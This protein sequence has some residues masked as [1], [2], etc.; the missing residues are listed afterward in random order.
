MVVEI[1]CVLR[2]EDGRAFEVDLT[3]DQQKIDFSR[4]LFIFSDNLWLD[5]ARRHEMALAMNA[6]TDEG[7]AGFLPDTPP[8][9]NFVVNDEHCGG[10]S[11]SKAPDL[12]SKLTGKLKDG[13]RLELA[14]LWARTAI[15]LLVIGCNSSCG[16]GQW[17]RGLHGVVWR[18]VQRDEVVGSRYVLVWDWKSVAVISAFVSRLVLEMIKRVM[19][20]SGV[21]AQLAEPQRGKEDAKRKREERGQGNTHKRW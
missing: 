5:V 1:K 19:P 7:T 6:K 3:I 13:K 21:E 9:A 11:K 16:H 8:A 17:R 12:V 18:V 2:V 14:A 10:P 15:V 4:L 20:F